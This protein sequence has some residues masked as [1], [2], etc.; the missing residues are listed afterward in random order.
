MDVSIV[1]SSAF[2]ASAWGLFSPTL[3]PLFALG[4]VPLALLSFAVFVPAGGELSRFLTRLAGYLLLFHVIREIR[5]SI[6]SRWRSFR[7]SAPKAI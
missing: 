2:S 5:S 1:S 7:S 3:L 4:V 6:P